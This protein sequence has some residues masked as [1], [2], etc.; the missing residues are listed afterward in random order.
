LSWNVRPGTPL[1]RLRTFSPKSDVQFCGIISYL[2][3]RHGGNVQDRQIVD[4]SVSSTDGSLA[5]K[6]A[7]D[8]QSP[9]YFQSTNQPNQWFRY[10]F[11]NSRVIPTH[12]C[13]HAHYPSHLLRSWVLKGSLDGS[14]WIELDRQHNNETANYTNPIVTFPVSRRFECRFIELEQTGKSASGS[15]CLILYAFEI[16]GQFHPITVT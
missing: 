7:A 12:Y 2:T 11:K 9:K 13:I 4:I 14:N 6:N 10:D 3:E 15:D 5:A 1:S 16:F 8:F